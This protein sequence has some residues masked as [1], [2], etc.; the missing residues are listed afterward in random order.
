MQQ[1]IKMQTTSK[2]NDTLKSHT[3]CKN[4]CYNKVIKI[5]IKPMTYYQNSIS[6]EMY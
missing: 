3:S 2:N 6:F 5:Q 1:A 4:I